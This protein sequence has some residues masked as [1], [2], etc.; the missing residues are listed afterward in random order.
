[1]YYDIWATDYC[2]EIKGSKVCLLYLCLWNFVLHIKGKV[3]NEFV[4]RV[5]RIIVNSKREKLQ[6]I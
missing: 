6:V 5:L 1:M 3:L 2:I 4:N